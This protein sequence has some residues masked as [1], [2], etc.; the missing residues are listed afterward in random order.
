M[1]IRIGY[2]LAF[3]SSMP[4]P[5]ILMLSVHPSRLND[6]TE[7]HRITFEPPIPSQNYTDHFSNICTR[8]V[9]PPGRLAV[10]SDNLVR[11]SGL[12]DRVEPDA[13]QI[14]VEDLPDASLEFLLG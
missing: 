14:P 2:H 5:T 12:P 6:L 1:K 3:N 8:I 4:T 13:K 9:M 10:S 7:P 11:D